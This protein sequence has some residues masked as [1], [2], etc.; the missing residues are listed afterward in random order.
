MGPLAA[1]NV[2]RGTLG[3]AKASPAGSGSCQ[4]EEDSGQARSAIRLRVLSRRETMPSITAGA[5]RTSAAL[6][7]IPRR[8]W[9]SGHSSGRGQLHNLAVGTQAQRGQC[10]GVLIPHSFRCADFGEC[11]R[12]GAR[13]QP[14]GPAGDDVL[15]RRDELR[16][17]ILARRLGRAQH[18]SRRLTRLGVSVSILARRLGRAQPAMAAT[19][20]GVV[21]YVSI[22]ARRLGRA[23]RG[24]CRLCL[25]S[26]RGF[27]PRP[28]VRP[29]ANYPRGSRR[30]VPV[31]V[32]IL[33]RRLGRAQPVP[34]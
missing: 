21:G 12:R 22:L 2:A 6:N 3:V 13:R 34:A 26:V 27:N 14:Q 18:G 32:S 17:S 19:T 11:H 23:Q 24:R 8:R 30:V 10:E 7:G 20:W 4:R 31:P 29:G 1:P 28:A 16:A 9:G 33:A 15:W 25:S 5:T